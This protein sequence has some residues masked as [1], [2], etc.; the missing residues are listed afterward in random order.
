MHPCYIAQMRSIRPYSRPDVLAKID[1]RTREARLL[2]S[3]IGELTA[4]VGGKPSAVQ[5]AL[6][7]QLAQL[8]LRI[9]V[10]DRK[11]AEDGAGEMTPHDERTYLAWH[12]SYT[13]GLH[14]LGVKGTAPEKTRSL[15]DYLAGGRTNADPEADHLMHP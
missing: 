4:H 15:A 12:N 11:M 13:R 2:K 9:A 10:M 14:R 8:R 5:V 6:I 7:G 1:G 3:T